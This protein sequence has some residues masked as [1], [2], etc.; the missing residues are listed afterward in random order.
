MCTKCSLVL[1]I[2]VCESGEPNSYR[3]VVNCPRSYPVPPSCKLKL[4]QTDLEYMCLHL[5]DWKVYF[6]DFWEVVRDQLVL[7]YY[8]V[9]EG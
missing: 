2:E 9:K 7:G 8:L 1:F 6:T 4:L 5:G 3:P